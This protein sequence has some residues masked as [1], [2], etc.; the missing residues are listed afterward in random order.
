MAEPFFFG[1]GKG[2]T[3][4]DGACV[5]KTTKT[6]N[7]Q[8]EYCSTIASYGCTFHR[9]HGGFCGNTGLYSSATLNTN[10]NYWGDNRIVNDIF[11]DN[12]PYVNAYANVDC[13]DTNSAVRAIIS[14]ESYTA[15][16]KCFMGTLYPTGA[17]S[18]QYQ[19]CLSYTC[20]K[21][22][23]G[24]YFLKLN[25]G[26]TAATCTAAGSLKVA[27]Y[28]GSIDCPDPTT[29]CTTVGIKY[30]KRGCL[31]RGTCGTDGKCKCNAGYTGSD[32]SLKVVTIEKEKK[33]NAPAF[34]KKD[35]M[36]GKDE[37]N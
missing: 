25:I 24:N 19:Y 2:C 14:G 29:F 18:K 37:K 15:G 1:K 13:E 23:T 35:I 11:S 20:A 17:L 10:Q 32:C 6:A 30:C 12:C 9:R 27:G 5:S 21:Q 22:T 4:L 34:D 28:Y 33:I 26:T 3:F 36:V 7:F 31:G 8:S 16:S